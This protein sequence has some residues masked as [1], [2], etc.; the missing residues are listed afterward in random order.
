[1]NQQEILDYLKANGPKTAKQ[2]ATENDTD[3]HSTRQK[4]RQLRKYSLIEPIERDRDATL[5]RAIG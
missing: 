3:L 4:L 2:I 5:W 1:M